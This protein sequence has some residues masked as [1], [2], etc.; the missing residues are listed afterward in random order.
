M[1]RKRI[2]GDIVSS[3]AGIGVGALA[4]VASVHYLSRPSSVFDWTVQISG[5]ITAGLIVFFLFWG[6][7]QSTPAVPATTT[8]P[9]QQKPVV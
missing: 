8:D 6:H 3:I 9:K 5:A 2:I 1:S 7:F 4:L